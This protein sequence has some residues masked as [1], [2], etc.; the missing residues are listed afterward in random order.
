MHQKKVK[1]LV[2]TSLKNS[3][4]F[5]VGKFLHSEHLLNKIIWIAFL[6]FTV[7]V[8]SFYLFSAVTSFFEYKVVTLIEKKSDQPS[9][10]PTITFCNYNKYYFDSKNLTD[11]I[12]NISFGYTFFNGSALGNYLESYYSNRYGQCY[13]F[14]SGKNL[15]NFSV[16]ILNL[17]IGGSDDSFD[18]FFDSPGGILIY[19]HDFTSPIKLI[20]S[21]NHYGC[22]KILL[23]IFSVF[24]LL[25]YFSRKS[26]TLFKQSVWTDCD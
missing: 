20:Q 17:T 14:N 18:M 11:F 13:R 12:Y 8:S 23:I 3:S 15:S 21:N 16:P 5:I 2:S 26:N 22:N 24:I 7:S 6:I 9:Q 10:F 25:F 4:S 1:T 19:V